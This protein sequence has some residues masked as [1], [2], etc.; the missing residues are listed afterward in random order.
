MEQEF[1]EMKDIS[2]ENLINEKKYLEIGYF[3]LKGFNKIIPPK[4]LLN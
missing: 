3:F 4:L 2:K 1:G